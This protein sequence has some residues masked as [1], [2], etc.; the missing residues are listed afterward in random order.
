MK[1]KS[2]GFGTGPNSTD[3]ANVSLYLDAA[4]AMN[5]IR[6]MMDEAVS[7]FRCLS[8]PVDSSSA[9]N[10]ALESLLHRFRIYRSQNVCDFVSRNSSAGDAS[11]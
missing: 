6:P 5:I 10:E 8:A 11:I 9:L 4:R 7:R 1:R 2:N 3:L